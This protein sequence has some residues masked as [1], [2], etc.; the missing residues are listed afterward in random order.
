MSSCRFTDWQYREVINVC[1]GAR[2]GFVC[3]LEAELPD[4]RI[5]AIYVP[6]PCRFFGCL[7]HCGYYRIPWS[8][9]RRVGDDIILVDADLSACRVGRQR[10]RGV[11]NN[12]SC[13]VIR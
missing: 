7:W 4:G 5:C 9:V 13:T 1:S 10:R 2:L 3:D 8:C 12:G 6:G 11:C